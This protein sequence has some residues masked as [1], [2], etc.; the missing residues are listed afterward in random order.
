MGVRPPAMSVRVLLEMPGRVHLPPR[1]DIGLPNRNKLP[2]VVVVV[3]VAVAVAVAV[4]GVG[5][6]MPRRCQCV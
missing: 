1:R 4:V 6:R 5:M 2:V 3:V